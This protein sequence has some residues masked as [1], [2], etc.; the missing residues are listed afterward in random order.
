[1]LCLLAV[2]SLLSCNDGFSFTPRTLSSSSART[3]PREHSF[4]LNAI[5]RVKK[6]V[7]STEEVTPK[8]GKKSNKKKIDKEEDKEVDLEREELMLDIVT[9]LM[10]K[11]NE[12]EKSGGG[13]EH[14]SS[15]SS[16]QTELLNGVLRIYCTHSQP[17]F[18]M[19]WQRMKQEFSTSTGKESITIATMTIIVIT[20]T[21]IIADRII[22][23]VSMNADTMQTH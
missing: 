2:L 11:L 7:L 20:I 23:V 10:E 8:A 6:N 14:S 22:A 17:N 3:A 12:M 18:G 19:P 21:M 9:Q 15:L 1:M 16:D 4:P 13:E 5:A